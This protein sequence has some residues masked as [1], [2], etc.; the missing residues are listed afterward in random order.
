MPWPLKTFPVC[1]KT[2][3]E[4]TAIEAGKRYYVNVI[5]YLDVWQ[6]SNIFLILW[7]SGELLP[8]FLQLL[9]TIV[10][11]LKLLPCIF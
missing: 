10:Q 5:W 11:V 3:W 1:Q 6:S 2:Q 9:M 4:K 8:E 7:L